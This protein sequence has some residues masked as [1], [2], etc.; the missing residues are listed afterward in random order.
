M[1]FLRSLSFLAVYFKIY[2]QSYNS[3]NFYAKTLFYSLS[4]IFRSWVFNSYSLE[5]TYSR[6]ELLRKNWSEN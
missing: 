5:G 6:I 4:L 3:V 1:C 2:I